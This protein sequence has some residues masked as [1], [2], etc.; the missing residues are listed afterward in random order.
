VLAALA[1]TAAVHGCAHAP[2]RHARRSRAAERTSNDRALASAL[3]ERFAYGPRPGEVERVAAVGAEAWLDRQL[4]PERIADGVA[5]AAMEPYRDVLRSPDAIWADENDDIPAGAPAADRAEFEQHLAM[6]ALVREVLSERQLLEVMTDFWVNHFNVFARKGPVRF[7]TADFVEHAIRPHALGRFEDL[8]VAT[9][10][11]PAMLVY[12][13][14]WRSMA[15]REAIGQTPARGLNENYARELLELHT[16]GV[17]GGYTQHDVGEVARLLTGWSMTP[18]QE[19][20]MVFEYRAGWHDEAEKTVL[21]ERFPAHGGEAEGLR[22]LHLL[23]E[24]PSTA[25]FVARKLVRR[26]V[27]DDPPPTLV[28]AV[29][30]TFRQTHGDIPAVLRTLV[31]SREFRAA[32]AQR[33][34]VKTPLEFVVSALRAVDAR[35]D[36]TS[37]LSRVVARL[38]QP[39]F[40]QPVPTGW[41][42]GAAAWTSS[43]AF[44]DRM[45][46]ALALGRGQLQGVRV[47]HDLRFPIAA[48]GHGLAP[49]V[50]G[51]LLPR[52]A[53]PRTA[54][55][56]DRA[57]TALPPRPARA[58]A[59]AMCLASPEFQRR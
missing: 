20:R 23:A 14:N 45:N 3:L 17:D 42:D 34:K 52:F 49:V 40:L 9:A 22:L 57:T 43:S 36:G 6:S 39:L 44:L 11:H 19:G 30:A 2:G 33:T 4:H 8:L 31:G 10:R 37:N 48:T 26:F 21:G 51:S 28:D 41:P 5:D 15:P 27:S 12:L 38:G 54:E 35:P 47:D 29:A 16:L 46:I 55:A 58:L 50:V 25:A 1:S 7:L 32:A 53:S 18:P 13:D 24:H 56:I 59:I